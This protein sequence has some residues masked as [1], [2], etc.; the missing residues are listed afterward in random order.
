MPSER[1]WVAR[2][3]ASFALAK[4]NNGQ[5]QMVNGQWQMVNGQWQM[6]NG[7]WQMVNGQ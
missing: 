7:Q 4:L 1:G 2:D 3:G 5:W 6:V